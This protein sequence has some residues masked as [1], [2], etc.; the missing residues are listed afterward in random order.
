MYSTS[1]DMVSTESGHLVVYIVT[2]QCEYVHRIYAYV[3]RCVGVFN[4][5]QKRRQEY[6]R[7]VLGYICDVP[8]I[9]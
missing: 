1:V 2:I 8:Q 3:P 5:L 7:D 6:I 4:Q 9:L